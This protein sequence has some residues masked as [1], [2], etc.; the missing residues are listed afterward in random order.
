[1]PDTTTQ[2]DEHRIHAGCAPVLGEHGGRII[3]TCTC[4]AALDVRAGALGDLL[5]GLWT[6]GRY[7]PDGQPEGLG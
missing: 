1:M 5:A 7:A 2:L 4:G 6:R 3:G